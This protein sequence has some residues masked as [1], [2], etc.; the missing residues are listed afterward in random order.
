M[1]QIKSRKQGL[2]LDAKMERTP[3][4]I[5]KGNKSNHERQK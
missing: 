5:E 1:N 2:G 3:L 4:E